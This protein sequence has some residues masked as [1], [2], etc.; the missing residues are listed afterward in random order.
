[1]LGHLQ[2]NEMYQKCLKAERKKNDYIKCL[3]NFFSLQNNHRL[4][5]TFTMAQELNKNVGR[6]LLIA[7]C[8]FSFIVGLIVEE[9]L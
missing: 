6:C 5:L 3:H 4:K 7:F 1:M 9:Q 8:G 2:H